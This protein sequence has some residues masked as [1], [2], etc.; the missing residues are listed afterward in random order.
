MIN[1]VTHR[2]GRLFVGAIDRGRTGIDEM[3]EAL[4]GARQFQHD[5][6]AHDVGGNIGKRVLQRIAD[7][8]L[9]RQV[10]DAGDVLISQG[11][12]RVLVGDIGL[13]KREVL[14]GG[15]LRQAGI[16]QAR[17]VIVAEIVDA[18]DDIAPRQQGV[19][20]CGA[21]KSSR[22]RDQYRR[23]KVSVQRLR[24]RTPPGLNSRSTAHL[25]RK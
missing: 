2:K 8:R 3:L 4:E 7:P 20:N 21:D 13:A 18:H 17:V 19:G 6:L 5:G 15:K 22:A 23:Q 1:R 16:L 11:H 10:Y 25:P 9:C 14:V 24:C 12:H